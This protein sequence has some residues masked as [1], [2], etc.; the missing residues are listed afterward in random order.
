MTDWELTMLLRPERIEAGLARIGRPLARWLADLPDDLDDEGLQASLDA[1]GSAIF[2]MAELAQRTVQEV[3]AHWAEQLDEAYVTHDLTRGLPFAWSGYERMRDALARGHGGPAVRGVRLEEL[4]RPAPADVDLAEDVLAGVRLSWAP[5]LR[6][7]MVVSLVVAAS[8]ALV[9]AS[10]ALNDALPPSQWPRF[11]HSVLSGD[12]NVPIPLLLLSALLSAAAT[13]LPGAWR[14]HRERRGRREQRRL[15]AK[16]ARWVRQRVAAKAEEVTGALRDWL[17][18]ELADRIADR[19]EQAASYAGIALRAAGSRD[20]ASARAECEDVMGL[21]LTD[22]DGE[23]LARRLGPAQPGELLEAFARE[24]ARDRHLGAELASAPADEVHRRLQRWLQVSI[25]R[26]LATPD[27]LQAA[28]PVLLDGSLDRAIPGLAPRPGADEELL[29]IAAVP[30]G[31][32][33]RTPVRLPRGAAVE[34]DVV[35]PSSLPDR[36][37][38]IAICRRSFDAAELVNRGG[39]REPFLRLEGG[40]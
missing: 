40:G 15:K 25:E 1:A 35:V 21:R 13:M 27:G 18:R 28:L 33:A 38:L 8:V 7:A 29:T 34:L 11:L 9:I 39:G 4:L 16:A 22:E 20:A 23:A 14:R 31:G 5:W 36:I 2:E 6:P 24:A 19:R 12:Q 17:D 32:D 30:I 10:L 3:Q 26:A 37:D